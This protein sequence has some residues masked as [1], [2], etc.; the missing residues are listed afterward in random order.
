[1]GRNRRSND[2]CKKA[3]LF[4]ILPWG[5][6]TCPEGPKDGGE[7]SLPWG[8]HGKRGQSQSQNELSKNTISPNLTGVEKSRESESEREREFQYREYNV[9]NHILRMW[10]G[11]PAQMKRNY[12]MRCLP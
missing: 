7:G 2:D 10:L 5:G 8:R 6:L 3:K 4:S 9:L 1:M 12:S 11:I